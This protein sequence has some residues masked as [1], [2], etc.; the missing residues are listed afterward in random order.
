MDAVDA[1]SGATGLAEMARR[2][3]LRVNDVRGV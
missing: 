3:A 2:V 1:Q